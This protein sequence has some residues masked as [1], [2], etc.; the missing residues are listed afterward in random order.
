[1][2]GAD[3]ALAVLGTT[4]SAQD[5]YSEDTGRSVVAVA[6]A[7]G[8]STRTNTIG[9]ISEQAQTWVTINALDLVRRAVL[10]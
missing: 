8:T 4:N 9:G 1:M 7:T 6:C 2:T 5:M 3:V 10:N